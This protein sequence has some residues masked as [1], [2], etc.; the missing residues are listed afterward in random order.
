MNTVPRSLDVSAKIRHVTEHHH[1]DSRPGKPLALLVPG[2][3]VA[4]AALAGVIFIVYQTWY[5]RQ[6]P[7]QHG[8]VFSSV[9]GTIYAGAVFVF[10]YG[11]ELYNFN[12]ALRLTAL[13]VVI[14]VFAVILV[15][16][17]FAVFSASK[18]SGSKSSSSSNKSSSSKGNS[19]VDRS[20]G[21][22]YLTSSPLSSG[23]PIHT[24][25]YAP[26]A[27]TPAQAAQPITILCQYCG[28]DV[29]IPPS[30]QPTALECPSCKAALKL[31]QS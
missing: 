6:F 29:T 19:G 24:R 11:Y 12:K 17:L 7:E 10:S 25:Q 23:A 26:V 22:P 1:D 30:N 13:I 20:V 9:L 8:I 18:D 28:T 16:A 5:L 2:A 14:T 3:I 31:E 27:P 15:A 21:L 4:L